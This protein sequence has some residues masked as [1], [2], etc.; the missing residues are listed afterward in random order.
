[1]DGHY[2]GFLGV[3]VVLLALR[4]GGGLLLHLDGVLF[5]CLGL[6]VGLFVQQRHRR[7]VQVQLGSGAGCRFGFSHL[8]SI[9]AVTEKKS[10][11]V[12]ILVQLN[13][14][15]TA[16]FK[17]NKD[18]FF[19]QGIKQKKMPEDGGKNNFVAVSCSSRRQSFHYFLEASLTPTKKEKKGKTDE[20]EN[21][22]S[23]KRGK[24]LE[25]LSLTA[26]SYNGRNCFNSSEGGAGGLY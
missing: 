16:S 14:Q 4:G 11:K 10:I 5:G 15:K 20:P 22:S 9:S 6:L 2:Y 17:L 19:Q 12:K 25:G 18:N 24:K 3:G 8:N 21:G 23:S 1:M 26:R 7:L 13:P